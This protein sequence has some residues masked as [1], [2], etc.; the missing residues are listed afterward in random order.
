VIGTQSSAVALVRAA[1][2]RQTPVTGL[3]ISGLVA[4]ALVGILVLLYAFRR[5]RHL[6]DWLTSRT[7]AARLAVT[8]LAVVIAAV[9]TGPAPHGETAADGFDRG[10]ALAMAA[11][12]PAG[13][14]D[15]LTRVSRV[16]ADSF[17]H[18]RHAAKLACLTCHQTGRGHGRLTFEQPRGCAICHHQAPAEAR[19]ASCH[20]PDNY[21]SP[22]R[23]TVTVTVPA[24]EPHAR[25]VDFLHARHA[26]RSC[27]DCHTTPVTLAPSPAAVQ[28]KDCHSDHHEAGRDCAACHANADPKSAHKGP[29]TAHRRCDACHTETTIARLTPTRTFCSTCHVEKATKHHDQKE[30]TVCHFL[31]EPGTYRSKL[32]RPRT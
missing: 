26:S 3:Q 1:A 29:E 16:A 23:V 30:C 21:A 6:Q 20:R 17:P 12:P 8:A 32:R 11:G 15:G 22:K 27:V 2:L 14:G 18:A 25:P 4:G 31:A 9:S 7:R 5:R 10:P 24:R 28:C 13:A 19:C